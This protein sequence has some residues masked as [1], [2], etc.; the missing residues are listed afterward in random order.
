ML[1]VRVMPTLLHKDFGLVKGERFHSWR[2]TG[3]AMQQ[4]KV[5]NLREVDELV[6]LDIT[7]SIKGRPP[8]YQLIDDLADD[9]FMPM[10]VGGGIR[11][12]DHARGVLQ[13]GADKVSINSAAVEHPELITQIAD[14]FG[15]QCV[16]VSIDYKLHADGTREMFTYSG[17]KPTGLD[18]V[19]FAVMVQERGAGEILLTSIDRDGTFAGYDVECIRNVSEAVS[20]PVIASGGA[21]SYEDMSVAIIEGRAS[22]VAAASIFHFSHLTPLEAKQYLARKG[23]PVRLVDQPESEGKEHSSR[24]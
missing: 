12:I 21:G 13:V 2:R 11:T 15:S 14:R 5:Y 7:A 1:K 18:P 9:C 3:S 6:L 23:L 10:T 17:S 22:A 8:D 24:N 20:I 4:I 16:V 19:S